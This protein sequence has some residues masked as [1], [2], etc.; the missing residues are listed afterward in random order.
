MVTG[1]WS[2]VEWT[3]T[4]LWQILKKREEKRECKGEE[5]GEIMDIFLELQL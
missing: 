1:G 5:E 3:E 2:F 4:R